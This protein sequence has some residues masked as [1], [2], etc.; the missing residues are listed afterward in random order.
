ML[1]HLLLTFKHYI[2]TKNSFVVHLEKKSFPH[3]NLIFSNRF[4][5]KCSGTF[6]TTRPPVTG[7]YP[8]WCPSCN[9]QGTPRLPSNRPRSRKRPPSST[10]P[11]AGCRSSWTALWVPELP[12]S[13]FVKLFLMS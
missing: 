11:P 7:W 1:K 6:A 12:F 5:T 10:P 3:I 13:K 2:I 9:V 8:R 4:S